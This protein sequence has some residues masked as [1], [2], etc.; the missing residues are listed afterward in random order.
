MPT[1]GVTDA[2]FFPMRLADIQAALTALFQSAFGPAVDLDARTP[3][4][5]ILGILAEQLANGW[6]IDEQVYGMYSPDTAFGA[7]LDNLASIT[8]VTRLPATYSQGFITITGNSGTM[9]PDSFQV[10]VSG[11]PTAIFQVTEGGTIGGSGTGTV[12]LPVQAVATGPLA[13]GAGTL[14]VIVTPLSGVASVTNS[15]D[16]I[17]GTDTET[18]AALRIRRLISLSR[19]GTAT[20]NGIY[21]ELMKVS[22]VV[23]ASVVENATDSV[24]GSGRPPHSFE[25]IV[26]GGADADVAAAIFAAKGAGIA[27]FGTS[28]ESV[29]DSQ[30]ISH[31]VNFSRPEPVDIYL[32]I[33]VTRNLDATKGPTYP[34]NG[35]AAIKAAIYAFTGAAGILGREVVLSQFYTP[36]NTV[37]GIWGIE[38]QAGLTGSDWSTSNIAM[39]AEQIPAF[40]ISRMTVVDV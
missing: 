20:L 19:A 37:Q 31:V 28:S 10:S 35:D 30:G 38:V 5:Q 8:N 12:E 15:D 24:D 18:D 3:L 16:A 13:A 4:G 32:K 33:T 21:N 11:N 1:Y 22:E 14:T 36:I 40:D 39:T 26:M 6:E 25:A 2:G 17:V 23:Q 9:I 27:T 7:V 34:S 29:Q